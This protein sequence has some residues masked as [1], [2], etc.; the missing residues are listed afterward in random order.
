MNDNGLE[1]TLNK[2]VVT[3]FSGGPRA[4][5]P[6][7]NI[8]QGKNFFFSTASRSALGPTQPTTQRILGAISTGV[9][10]LGREANHSPQTS[11]GVKN[12]GGLPPFPPLLHSVVFN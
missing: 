5:R 2:T 7:Y 3:Y 8:Q 10:R 6:G 11:D 9:K 4:G 1:T 12:D